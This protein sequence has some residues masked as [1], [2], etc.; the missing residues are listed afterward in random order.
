MLLQVIVIGLLITWITN[1][2]ALWRRSLL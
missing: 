2:D 1:H